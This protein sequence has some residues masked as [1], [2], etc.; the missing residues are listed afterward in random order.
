MVGVHSCHLP[1]RQHGAKLTE[2]L[3]IQDFL[4][5]YYND[6]VLKLLYSAR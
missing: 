1:A 4:C 6:R 2:R 5:H 3:A